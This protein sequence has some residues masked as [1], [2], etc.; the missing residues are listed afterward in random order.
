MDTILA[1]IIC[2]ACGVGAAIP[3]SLL[4]FVALT[5]REAT[6][7]QREQEMGR[8]GRPYGGYPPVVVIPD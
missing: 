2:V 5:R 4:L 6:R 7:A 8:A 3:T 1:L